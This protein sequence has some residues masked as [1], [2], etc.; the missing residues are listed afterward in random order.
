MIQDNENKNV[1]DNIRENLLMTQS[2]AMNNNNEIVSFNE[3]KMIELEEKIKELEEINQKLENEIDI[4]KI[5]KMSYMELLDINHEESDTEQECLDDFP[6]DIRREIEY[7]L[8]REDQIVE[9][10]V[11]I[12]RL[13]YEMSEYFHM[14]RQTIPQ[15]HNDYDRYKM[16]K[17]S[18]YKMIEVFYSI[19]NGENKLD[20]FE[21]LI[22]ILRKQKKV[23]ECD[24]KISLLQ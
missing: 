2:H 8:E 21:L 22:K 15:N 4:L 5:E 13:Q 18:F 14:I 3:N 24:Q 7:D 20:V 11:K 10:G 9:L 16:E 12:S 17:R 19:Y 6:S 23:Y 1:V